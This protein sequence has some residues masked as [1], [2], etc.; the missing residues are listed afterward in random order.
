MN[1]YH[2]ILIAFICSLF[3]PITSAKIILGSLLLIITVL[4][5]VSDWMN[6]K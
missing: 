5:F 1:I 4:F 6:I 2:M 3:T